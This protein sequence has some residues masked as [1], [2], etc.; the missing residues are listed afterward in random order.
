[1]W[2]LAPAPQ[3]LAPAPFQATAAQ[4]IGTVKRHFPPMERAETDADHEL[5]KQPAQEKWPAG[6]PAGSLKMRNDLVGPK[7]VPN[8]YTKPP[9]TTRATMLTCRAVG[10]REGG[11]S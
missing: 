7:C 1:V 9:G 4:P 3:V 8:R 11:C 5:E 10:S 6:D 2:Y